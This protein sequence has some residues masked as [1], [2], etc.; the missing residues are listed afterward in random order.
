MT[1]AN[2]RADELENLSI[3]FVLGK[4]DRLN[5]ILLAQ[6]VGD[7]LVGNRAETRKGVPEADIVVLLL[8]L[9]LA[10]LLEA[11]SFL[12]YEE[13]AKSVSAHARVVPN[14]DPVLVYLFT[15]T[16]QAQGCLRKNT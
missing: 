13:L 10:K 11:D 1:L 7:L 5:A 6:E 9:R 8:L 16:G 14:R 12:A 4:V 15:K 2:L 3:D